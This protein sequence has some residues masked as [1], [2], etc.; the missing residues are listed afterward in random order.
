MANIYAPDWDNN[1]I[2]V[3]LSDDLSFI[4]TIDL[5]GKKPRAVAFYDGML[6]IPSTSNTIEVYDASTYAFVASYTY[7]GYVG[8]YYSLTLDGTTLWLI[9]DTDPPP[10]QNGIGVSTILM[11]NLAAITSSVAGRGYNIYFS[12]GYIYK[13]QYTTNAVLRKYLST[14]LSTQLASYT[15]AAQLI[16]WVEVGNYVFAITATRLYKLNS[17]DLS[18]VTSIANT[19]F[20]LYSL[21]GITADASYLYVSART[22]EDLGTSCIFKLAVADLSLSTSSSTPFVYYR[23]LG[24]GSTAPPAPAPPYTFGNIIW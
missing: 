9:T 16:Q 17:A 22:S 23:F 1:S 24:I 4:A 5:A 8:T 2:D 3:R 6:Y 18:L 19:D 15:A 13:N 10:P 20:T 21:T 11:A 12:N 14:D 7:A